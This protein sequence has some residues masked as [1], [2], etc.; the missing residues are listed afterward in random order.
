MEEAVRLGTAIVLGTSVQGVNVEGNQVTLQDGRTLEAD[1]IVGADGPWPSFMLSGQWTI[2]NL[3]TGLWST[4]RESF[5][6]KPSPPIPTGDLAYRATLSFDQLKALHDPIIDELC[7]RRS[8]TLWMG[9]FKHSVFYPVRGGKEF[10]LVL[11]RPDDLPPGVRTSEG[12]ISEMRATF[13]GWDDMWVP[14]FQFLAPLHL[15]RRPK[16]T[17]VSQIDQDH[18]VHP[19]RFEME[20]ASS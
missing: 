3:I 20:A 6:N 15:P 13:E 10:N 5:L 12:D 16:L 1:V 8:V 14:G 18:L 7:S 17:V 4:M 11:L 19:H 9:P 2:S